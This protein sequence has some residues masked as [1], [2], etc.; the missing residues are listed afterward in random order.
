M[1]RIEVSDQFTAKAALVHYNELI[2][3]ARARFLT[4]P[5]VI[6]ITSQETDPR[7]MAA[8]LVHFS[9]LSISITEPAQISPLLQQRMED[10]CFPSPGRSA[11]DWL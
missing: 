2:H 3:P 5:G 11:H 6:G 4:G 9:A 7:T 8:F 10:A 1:P